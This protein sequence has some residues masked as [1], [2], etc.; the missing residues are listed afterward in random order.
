MDVS[1]VLHTIQR[2]TCQADLTRLKSRVAAI[3]VNRTNSL[4][5][6]ATD[7]VYG[8][9]KALLDDFADVTKN[10]V[11]AITTQGRRTPGKACIP[12]LQIPG[13]DRGPDDTAAYLQL[14][15]AFLQDNILPLTG[16]LPGNRP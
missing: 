8:K 1:D 15:A 11:S 14:L 5:H 9:H 12:T 13:L 3:L 4:E 7:S 16:C 2:E 10:P 6:V